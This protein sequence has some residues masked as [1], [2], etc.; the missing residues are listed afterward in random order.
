MLFMK[1]AFLASEAAPYA[2]T[3]GLADVV[4][5]LPRY[6][7]KLGLELALFLPFYLEV[8]KKNFEL[9]LAAE[10]R[11][12]W[13]KKEV[14]IPLWEHHTPEMKVYFLQN[15][16]YYGREGIYGT[17]SGDHPDNAVRFAFYCLACL[18]AMKSIGFQP[19]LI[20]AHDWQAALSLAYRRYKY[21]DDPFF[22]RTGSLFTIHNLA[23]QGIFPAEILEQIGLPSAVFRMEEMEFY[24]RVNFLKAGLVYAD[25]LSTVSPTYSREIQQPGYGYGLEGVLQSRASSLYGILNGIDNS[26]WDPEKDPLI[27]YHFSRHN[28]EG[29]RKCKE[30]LIKYFSFSSSAAEEPLIGMVSRLAD[31]KGLDLVVASLDQLFSLRL[32]LVILGQGDK[33]Y[34]ELL[35][36]EQKK[37]KGRLGVKIAFDDAL[38]HLIFAGSDFFLIPSRFEPCGLTQMY[39]LRYGTIP[40]VRSTGGLVDTVEEFDKATLKGT[41]FRFNEYSGIA[42][43]RAVA[44][45]L[46][47]YSQPDLWQRL[48]QNAMAADFSWERSAQ[49]YLELYNKILTL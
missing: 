34:H 2:K 36:A 24:G 9:R 23:Y 35:S 46:K 45:A 13:Q 7:S 40:I 30:E 1:V 32:N 33:K 38:A 42:L 11:F 12:I 21:N 25:A 43:V 18:E 22:Q 47:V 48:I 14:I 44:S 39:S 20:H 5:S 15:D 37:R 31:Q 3:G 6:L 41:G 8:Q 10:L 4:G 17:S 19:D 16:D 27:P 26:A 28:L 49:Q 29:K